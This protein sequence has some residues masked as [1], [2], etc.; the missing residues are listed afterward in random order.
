MSLRC[1]A[2]FPSSGSI[3]VS[4]EIGVALDHAAS[5]MC[6]SMRIGPSFLEAVALGT[7]IACAAARWA[8][9]SATCCCAETTVEYRRRPAA[10][11]SRSGEQDEL[12]TVAV[13]VGS[14]CKASDSRIGANGSLLDAYG[15]FPTPDSPALGIADALHT[16]SIC[17]GPVRQEASSSDHTPGATMKYLCLIYDDETRWDR[18]SK[19]DATA[20]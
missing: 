9:V 12:S 14:L 13:G 20:G 4:S 6:P 18:M 8:T 7:G 3:W 19:E 16:M 10:T 15:S 17:P 1:V 5:S 2:G 11:D